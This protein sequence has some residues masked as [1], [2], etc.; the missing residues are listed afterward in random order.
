MMQ[1]RPGLSAYGALGSDNF[2]EAINDGQGI[3]VYLE[4]YFYIPMGDERRFGF[5]VVVAVDAP[6][7]Y[8]SST[9]GGCVARK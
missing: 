9:I 6:K 7:K 3:N 4:I 2:G 1:F 5:A 8:L